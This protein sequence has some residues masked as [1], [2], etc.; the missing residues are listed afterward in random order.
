[1]QLYYKVNVKKRN[2]QFKKILSGIKIMLTDVNN[3]K[4]N[5]IKKLLCPRM[6]S[7]ARFSILEPK[8]ASF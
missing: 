2:L 7:H 3:I 5:P 4:N 6:L 1:M 8:A